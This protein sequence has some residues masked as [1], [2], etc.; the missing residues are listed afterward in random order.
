[1][2]IRNEAEADHEA[3]QAILD[4]AFEGDAESRLVSQL[5]LCATPLIS[6]VAE[7]DGEVLGHILFSPITLDSDPSLAL[8]GLAPMAVLP[9]QQRRGIGAALI[10]AGLK[11]CRQ[12]QIGAVVVLGHPGYYPRFGFR[13]SVSFDIS[14]EY[15]VPAE[16]FML[17]EIQA[18]YMNGHRGTVR[19]HEQ[20]SKL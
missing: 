4:S 18:G 6:L 3:V 7:Q 9:D 16:A 13:E 5:R 10:E 1:M 17:L 8:M 12:S 11:R 19:Y 2:L 15:D 20:F 14:C